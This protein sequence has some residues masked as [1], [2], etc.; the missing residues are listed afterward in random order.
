MLDLPLHHIGVATRS[1]ECEL[2]AY[3]SLGYQRVFRA[4]HDPAQGIRGQ[5]IS[6][7]NGPALEL[8]ENSGANGP[9]DSWLQRGVKLYHM[10]Y[11]TRN[12]EYDADVLREE[13]R[14]KIIVPIMPAVFFEKICFAMLPNMLLI[15]LVQSRKESQ[16]PH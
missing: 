15:E 9:L 8:L 1:I 13:C 6:C 16:W 2:P 4:F 7:P 10:A 12:I 3:L 14:A 11:Q 5:F